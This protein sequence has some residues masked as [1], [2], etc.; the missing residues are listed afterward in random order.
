MGGILDTRSV[1][2]LQGS[3]VLGSRVS[4]LDAI[5]ISPTGRFNMETDLL[6]LISNL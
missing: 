3:K 1:V 2:Q 6:M 4:H 5:K